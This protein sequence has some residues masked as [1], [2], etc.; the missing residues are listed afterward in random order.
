MFEKDDI[1]VCIK[2]QR[3]SCGLTI[4]HEGAIVQVK[5]GINWIEFYKSLD[6]KKN[7]IY[8]EASASAFRIGNEQEKEA[9]Y[10][11]VR[12]ISEICRLQSK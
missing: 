1:I 6:R 8:T 5:G 9:F 10:N 11:G 3:T 12:N 2:K 7:N 4:V